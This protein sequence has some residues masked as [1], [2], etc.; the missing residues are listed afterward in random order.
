M[1]KPTSFSARQI[2]VIILVC[3]ISIC[4]RRGGSRERDGEV[5]QL[6]MI[7]NLLDGDCVRVPVCIVHYRT[8]QPIPGE[9]IKMIFRLPATSL[10]IV[11]SAPLFT[12][13]I[14][15]VVTAALFFARAIPATA[16]FA[17]ST[18]SRSLFLNSH[19]KI[20]TASAATTMNQN[21]GDYDDP[22]IYLEEVESEKSIAFAKMANEQCLSRLGDPSHTDTY[23][24]VLAALESDERIPHV[25][26]L[27]YDPESGDMLLY[28]FWKDSKVNNITDM[29]NQCESI[30]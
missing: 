26:L 10:F 18:P 3:D 17:A 4:Q 2:Y 20:M 6:L 29:Q 13:N 8:H 11:H 5:V 27:G 9:R 25:K 22:Y 15:P 16:A 23:R 12:R 21:N 30:Y 28:N 1:R 7:N 14:P 24:R 19:R